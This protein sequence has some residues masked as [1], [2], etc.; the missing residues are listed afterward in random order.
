VGRIA[1]MQPHTHVFWAAPS[2]TEIDP[3]KV[4][5]NVG[6]VAAERSQVQTASQKLRMWGCFQVAETA[7]AASGS[8]LASHISGNSAF[9]KPNSVLP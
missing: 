8:E 7:N 3:G 9:D 6:A 4:N 2:S 5:V 1:I